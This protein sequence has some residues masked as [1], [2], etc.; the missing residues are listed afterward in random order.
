[1]QEK[2]KEMQA[3]GIPNK[4]IAKVV[5]GSKLARKAD[6]REAMAKALE[7]SGSDASVDVSNT[8]DETEDKKARNNEA[9]DDAKKAAS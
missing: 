6:R 1:W 5:A 7:A 8:R 4:E 3:A 2:I 9:S